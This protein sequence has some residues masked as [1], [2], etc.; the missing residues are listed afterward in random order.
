[1]GADSTYAGKLV[2]WRNS[3]D[4]RHVG[5]TEGSPDAFHVPGLAADMGEGWYVSAR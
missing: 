1:M 2:D 4:H 5:L 3:L